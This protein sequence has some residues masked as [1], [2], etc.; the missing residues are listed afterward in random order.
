M[1]IGREAQRRGHTLYTYTPDRL[2]LSMRGLTARGHRLTLREELTDFFTL[3]TEETLALAEMDVVLLRQDPPFDMAYI[4]STYLLEQLPPTTH[5]FNHPAHVRNEPEKLMPLHFSRF[6]PPTLISAEL[7]AIESFRSE[8]G[9]VVVKPLYGN[10]GKA[11][12]LLRKEDSNLPAL[13]E[14]HKAFSKEPLMVQRFLP[15]VISEDRRIILIDGRVAGAMGRIP[16]SGEIRANFRVGGSPAAVTLTPKQLEIC[17][18][19]GPVLRE[20]NLL[21]AGLDVIGDHLT[22]INITSPT[23]MVQMNALYGLSL[24]VE[25]W[26]ALEKKL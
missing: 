11:V 16:A 20:K 2:S 24:E 1:L 5:V 14:L 18:A 22:E 21:F 12:F 6:M 25:F 26:D 10:G 8:H 4:T 19:V 3:G 15:E 7:T 23:G 13:L 9:D 17:E